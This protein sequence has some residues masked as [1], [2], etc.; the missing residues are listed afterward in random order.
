MKKSELKNIIKECVKEVIFEEGVLSGLITE[1][2]K[3]LQTTNIVQENRMASIVNA[4]KKT[5]NPNREQTKKAI[6]SAINNDYSDVK[7]KFSNPSLFEGTKPIPSSGQ[8]GALSGVSPG[9]SG[10]DL[11]SIPGM[12]NWATIAEGN[13]K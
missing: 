6:M 7:N 1:V 5:S 4:S 12:G 13:R 9:D 11:S 2:A 10:V 3:G 8:K